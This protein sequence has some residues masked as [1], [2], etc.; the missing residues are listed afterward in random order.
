M[1]SDTIESNATRNPKRRR[2]GGKQPRRQG[3]RSSRPEVKQARTKS[4]L[5]AHFLPTL[6]SDLANPRRTHRVRVASKRPGVWCAE[7]VW[8]NELGNACL[9]NDLTARRD[10][11]G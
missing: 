9:E 7:I 11:C 6:S 10:A 1:I 2:A 5:V 4:Q 8:A 3:P